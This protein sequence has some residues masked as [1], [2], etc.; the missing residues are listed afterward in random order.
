V[1][2]DITLFRFPPSVNHEAS[3]FKLL[4][5]WTTLHTR[6]EKLKQLVLCLYKT[7][8]DVHVISAVVVFLFLT[9]LWC[10]EAIIN[11]PNFQPKLILAAPTIGYSLYVA[12]HVNWPSRTVRPARQDAVYLRRM[13]TTALHVIS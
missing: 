9:G 7:V 10:T 1:L 12:S 5:E 3:C 8:L 4:H 11:G 2:I 13:T 6:N